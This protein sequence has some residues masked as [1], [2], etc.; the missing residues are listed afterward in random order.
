MSW[1]SS[2]LPVFWVQMRALKHEH[3]PKFH[4]SQE[5]CTG[6]WILQKFPRCTYKHVYCCQML[7]QPLHFNKAASGLCC[8]QIRV[9]GWWEL[10]YILLWSRE[11][12]LLSGFW[13]ILPYLHHH[14]HHHFW[15]VEEGYLPK[16]RGFSETTF[17][18]PFL[19]PTAPSFCRRQS[20]WE[21]S[22]VDFPSDYAHSA[23]W[24]GL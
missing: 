21:C 18:I 6:L 5:T 11:W 9:P 10:H 23:L 16:P 24:W 14:H 22:D 1:D 15:E 17:S 3:G 7:M 8:S 13:L 20:H 4:L 19:S 12:Q 2:S